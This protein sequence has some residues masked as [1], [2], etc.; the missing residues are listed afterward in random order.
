MLKVLF[1][2]L[3]IDNK[4]LYKNYIKSNKRIKLTYSPTFSSRTFSP[5]F[6][7]LLHSYW[8]K[9]NMLTYMEIHL[10][11]TL[12]VVG[13]L[14][15]ILK[16]FHSS[17][18]TFKYKFLLTIAFVTASVWDNYIVYHKAWSYC[19]TCVVIVIG[20]VPLEEYMFFIIMTVMTVAFANL[21]MRWH[22]ASIFIK[23]NTPWIQSFFIRFVPILGLLTIAYKAWVSEM[24]KIKK[25]STHSID[26]D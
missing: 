14:L 24:L 26:R 2:Y 5:L 6:Y 4:E 21:M 23:P 10:Y 8:K 25:K 17:Q 22:L 19:P 9:K 18:D 3:F 13:L 7:T 15:W 11:F 16:P 1:F 20:F 12:P